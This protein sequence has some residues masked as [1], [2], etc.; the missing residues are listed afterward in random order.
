M[1]SN[2]ERFPIFSILV[3]Y[4][5]IYSGTVLDPLPSR[6]F[7]ETSI[8]AILP[9]YCFFFKLFEILCIHLIYFLYDIMYIK[10]QKSRISG[11]LEQASDFFT[12]KTCF[13]S[14]LYILKKHKLRKFF[15]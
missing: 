12:I 5:F 9:Q 3:R 7:Y 11:G 13:L 2:I 14:Q 15:V 1:N 4:T 6:I 10:L 8:L